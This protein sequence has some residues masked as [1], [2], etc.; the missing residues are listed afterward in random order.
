MVC[1][2]SNS[3][4]NV[5]TDSSIIQEVISTD[6][7]V[8]VTGSGGDDTTGQLNSIDYPFA[9]LTGALAFLDLYRIKKGK[10]VTIQIQKV[11]RS[12]TTW[13]DYQISGS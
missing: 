4:I 3:A 8:Y 12:T 13:N 10:S 5:P 6:S 2:Y 9:T 11:D 1:N 7:Y